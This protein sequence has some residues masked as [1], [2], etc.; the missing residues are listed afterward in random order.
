[1]LDTLHGNVLQHHLD[2]AV[3]LGH[4][5]AM[6]RDPRPPERANTP[7]ESVKLTFEVDE[8]LTAPATSA[9]SSDEAR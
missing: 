4:S 8:R 1:M 7:I 3:P 5:S 9:P 6:L 2:N